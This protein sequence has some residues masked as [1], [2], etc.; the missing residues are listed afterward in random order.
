MLPYE[1]HRSNLLNFKE[2]R[3]EGRKQ[4]N[5]IIKTK[6]RDTSVLEAKRQILFLDVKQDY[7]MLSY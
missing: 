3:A 1:K 6:T 5:G 7:L 2:I 4:W